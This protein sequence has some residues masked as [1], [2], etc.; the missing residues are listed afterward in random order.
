MPH[1][2][3]ET[4]GQKKQGSCHTGIRGRSEYGAQGHGK[5]LRP[6]AH[7]WDLQT[8]GEPPV[9]GREAAAMGSRVYT[10]ANGSTP[11]FVPLI[12]AFQDHKPRQA[13]SQEIQP[14]IL[15]DLLSTLR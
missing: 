1:A 9:C 12:P 7:S 2:L 14:S 5:L 13:C 3:R 11:A 10:S 6:R 8:S 4:Q 15:W